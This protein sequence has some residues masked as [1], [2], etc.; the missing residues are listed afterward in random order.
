[1]DQ[2]PV[3]RRQKLKLWKLGICPRLTWLLTIYEFPL[4]WIEKQLETSVTRH[5]KKWANLARSANPNILYLPKGKGG[6]NLPS[7]TSL[8]KS[9]QVSRQAQ[10]LT[11]VDPCVRKIAEDGLLH[12]LD[13]QRQKF[14][15]AVVVRDVMAEDPSQTR[16]KLVAVVKSH[17]KMEDSDK[18]WTQLC[19]LPRQGQLAR[20]FAATTSPAD[21]W[22]SA[23]QLLPKE[24]WKFP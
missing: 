3:T 1:M 22:A 18:Q 11:S 10:L 17:V 12:Q 8:Y 4:S 13:A 23:L 7:I 2:C 14:S 24:V 5:L 9:L 20:E 19:S 16:R 6:L 21:I 15:P